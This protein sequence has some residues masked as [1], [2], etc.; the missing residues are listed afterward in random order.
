MWILNPYFSF[1][2]FFEDKLDKENK[3]AIYRDKKNLL[4]DN[5]ENNDKLQRPNNGHREYE[6]NKTTGVITGKHSSV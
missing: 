6:Y 4:K 2:L 5:P 3:I 1:V